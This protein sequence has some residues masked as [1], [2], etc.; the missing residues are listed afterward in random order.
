MK[1]VI[2]IANDLISSKNKIAIKDNIFYGSSFNERSNFSAQNE[3][4]ETFLQ[5]GAEKLNGFQQDIC[6]RYF[7]N[8]FQISEKQ[9]WAITFALINL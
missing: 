4:G 6:K 8:K 1:S 5:I 9:S 3:I 7:E 2:E